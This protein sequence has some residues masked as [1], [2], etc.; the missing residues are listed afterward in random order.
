MSLFQEIEG[1]AAVLVENGIFKQ[2][3]LYQ[4]DG[5]IFAKASGGFVKLMVDG[6]TTKAGGRLRIDFM[7]IDEQLYRDPLGRL[8]L[9]SVSG[10]STLP[11]DAERKLLGA[12]E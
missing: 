6:S 10:A 12:P 5:F 2:V 3:P 4:R 9:P 11:G 1:A 8:C 7:T